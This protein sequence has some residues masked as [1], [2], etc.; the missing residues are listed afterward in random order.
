MATPL[1]STASAPALFQPRRG[2]AG[3]NAAA[4][5]VERPNAGAR[6]GCAVNT[7]PVIAHYA[8]LGVLHR[9]DAS[10]PVEEVYDEARALLLS[11]S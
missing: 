11:L 4:R 7:A 9:I 2:R 3:A 8:R 10:R 6:K 5:G 1:H